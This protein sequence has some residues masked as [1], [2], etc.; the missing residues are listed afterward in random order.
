MNP[1]I[2][3][4]LPECRILVLDDEAPNVVL[5]QRLLKEEGYRQVRGLSDSREFATAYSEFKPE[6]L[7]LDLHM[8]YVSG[9]DILRNLEKIVNA[10]EYLPV[11]VITADFTR[12]TRGEALRLGATDF[13][14]KPFHR[15]EVALR[16]R[17]QLYIR[18][19]QDRLRRQNQILDRRVQERTRDLSLA[20]QEILTRLARAAEFRDDDTGLHTQRVGRM[21]ELLAAAIKLEPATVELIGKAAPLHDL[22]KIGIPDSILLKPGKLT[23]EEYQRMKAHAE[24]GASILNGT[25]VPLLRCA[26]TIALTHHERWD[27]KGYPNGLAGET[28]PIEGRVVAVAD[29]FD[30]LTHSRPYKDAWP[31]EKARE[32]ISSQ[33]GRQFDPQVVDAFLALPAPESS[34]LQ[35]VGN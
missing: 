14:T 27:G 25:E 21:A 8:P 34:A 4:D 33:R 35:N 22:G 3:K 10:D 19:L 1:E 28:I 18:L 2:V 24:I 31:V 15:G 32:E 16:L 13:L 30:A 5:L 6:I 26:R 9:F 20:H 29:V 7:L 11:I 17:N 12:E 23:S